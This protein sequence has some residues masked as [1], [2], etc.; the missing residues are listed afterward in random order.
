MCSEFHCIHFDVKEMRHWEALNLFR[1]V[2]V[3]MFL[4]GV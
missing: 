4:H 1:V 3:K 2:E